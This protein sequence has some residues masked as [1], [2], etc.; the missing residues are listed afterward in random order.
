MLIKKGS[1]LDIVN[2]ISLSALH[3]ATSTNITSAIESLL[4]ARADVNMADKEGRTPLVKL[5]YT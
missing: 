4:K 1:M 3:E 5:L 2:K